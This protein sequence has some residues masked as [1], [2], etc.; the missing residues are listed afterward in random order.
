M[1]V[2]C[3]AN[4]LSTRPIEDRSSYFGEKDND[5]PSDGKEG[6]ERR[7]ADEI[8]AGLRKQRSFLQGSY[9]QSA[10]YQRD[11]AGEQN[12]MSSETLV[13][14]GFHPLL[15]K[16]EILQVKIIYGN[17][18]VGQCSRVRKVKYP[19]LL[20][21]ESVENSTNEVSPEMHART[22][23]RLNDSFENQSSF[24]DL[25]YVRTLQIEENE[26]VED[27]WSSPAY[28]EKVHYRFSLDGAL[29]H[30]DEMSAYLHNITFVNVTV[31][32]RCLSSGFDDGK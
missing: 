32:E 31:T 13:K 23:S 16:D 19:V 4:A 22:L 12:A 7:L 18:C 1:I 26:T 9:H 10:I 3:I 5:V 30:L 28:W 6:A 20:N 2:N 8:R 24:D 11:M 15:G 25:H 29:L 27:T 21:T 17:S 14:E